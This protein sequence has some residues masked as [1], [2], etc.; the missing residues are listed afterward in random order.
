MTILGSISTTQIQKNSTAPNG[1]SSVDAQIS[2]KTNL[3]NMLLL[4]KGEEN[5]S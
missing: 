5:A 3:K 2:I 1:L 4:S